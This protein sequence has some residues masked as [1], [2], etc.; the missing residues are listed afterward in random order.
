MPW[1]THP[2]FLILFFYNAII[3]LSLVCEEALLRSGVRA[4]LQESLLQS[5]VGAALQEALL[6]VKLYYISVRADSALFT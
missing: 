3:P 6:H 5:G 1:D 2:N 4:T